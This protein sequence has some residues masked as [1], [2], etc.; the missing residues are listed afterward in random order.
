MF[1]FRISPSWSAQAVRPRVSCQQFAP[2]YFLEEPRVPWA[3]GG[4]GSPPGRP[5]PSPPGRLL[6]SRARTSQKGRFWVL[7]TSAF[8]E[9]YNVLYIL[10]FRTTAS[11]KFRFL[12]KFGEIL[13]QIFLDFGPG[14]TWKSLPAAPLFGTPGPLNDEKMLTLIVAAWGLWALEASMHLFPNPKRSMDP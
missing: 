3:P 13:N 2:C 5:R 10:A 11:Q 7:S 9:K 1:S 6:R 8:C 4:P 12:L 14:G